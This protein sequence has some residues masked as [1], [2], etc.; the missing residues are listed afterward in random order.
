MHNCHA[1]LKVQS[2]DHST[3]MVQWLTD[4]ESSSSSSS[5]GWINQCKWPL[6]ACIG[7][8]SAVQWPQPAIPPMRN[9]HYRLHI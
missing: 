8:R 2:L 9:P 6:Y 5:S 4:S 3:S 7:Q 1:C